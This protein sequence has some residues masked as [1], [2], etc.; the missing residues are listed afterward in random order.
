MRELRT[1]LP[2]LR[3]YQ[4]TYLLGLVLVLVSNAFTTAA[5]RFL[6]RGIDQIGQG[7]LV[8]TIVWSAVLLVAV[9]IVGG[10]GRFGM[11]QTLNSGSR[12]IETEMRDDLFAHLLRQSASF[13]DRH[14]T[15]D[16]AQAAILAEFNGQTVGYGQISCP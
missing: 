2:Y 9:T 14:P 10:V 1:L 4:G 6:E 7:A 12:H 16:P 13:F 11:R 15:G 8:G 5:P 3:R